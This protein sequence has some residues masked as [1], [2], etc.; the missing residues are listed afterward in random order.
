MADKVGADKL[1]SYTQRPQRP[2][3]PGFPNKPAPSSTGAITVTQALAS[4]ILRS[5]YSQLVAQGAL[6]KN[7]TNPGDAATYLTDAQNAYK[8]AYASYQLGNYSELGSIRE[9]R[10]PTGGRSKLDP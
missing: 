4:R 10:R 9:D 5:T 7:A 6:V 2:N 3:R 1:P 8:T